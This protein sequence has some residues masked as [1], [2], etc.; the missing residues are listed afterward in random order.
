MMYRNYH[1][2]VIG[3]MRGIYH[4]TQMGY[5]HD[6]KVYGSV[7]VRQFAFDL[8]TMGMLLF[9]FHAIGAAF[10]TGWLS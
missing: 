9:L 3:L 5:H 10:Q 6:T 7:W 1:L 8:L 4:A 2:Q